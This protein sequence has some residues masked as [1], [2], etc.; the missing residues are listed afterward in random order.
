MPFQISIISDSSVYDNKQGNL[1]Y[2]CGVYDGDSLEEFA[3]VCL[4][5]HICPGIFFDDRRRHDHFKQIHFCSFDFDSGCPSSAILA[6]IAK[7]QYVVVGS[8]NHLKDKFDGKGVIE[9]YHVFIPLT[10]PIKDV[11]LYK[12]TCRK[13]GALNQWSND[14]SCNEPARYYYK[15]SQIISINQ[16]GETIDLERFKKMQKLEEAVYK[17]RREFFEEKN[18]KDKSTPC[19]KFEKTSYFRQLEN[20]PGGDGLY[21]LRCSITGAMKTCGMSSDEAIYYF[22]RYG[23]F[24]GKFGENT[25]RRLY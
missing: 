7:Y 13:F 3:N 23:A 18:K 2:V 4:L 9:R 6:D 24:G 14:S 12:Y 8:K 16:T 20:M 10:K 1:G 15:H 17:R 11:A 5:S 21:S 25:L 19:Q 22:D